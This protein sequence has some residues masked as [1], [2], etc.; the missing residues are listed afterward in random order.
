MSSDAIRSWVR[1]RWLHRVHRTV[2]AVGHRGLTADGRLMAAVLACGPGAVVSHRSAARLWGVRR[3]SSRRI[4]LTIPRS[5]SGMAGVTAY[6][7]RGLR[8]QDVTTRDGFPVT[9]LPRTLIDLAGVVGTAELA[10]AVEAAE[11]LG[12]FDLRAVAEVLERGR[13][14]RGT[15]KLRRLLGAWR[16]PPRTRS[17]MERFFFEQCRQRNL[18]LPSLNTLVE[19]VEVDAY[20]EAEDVIVELDSWEFHGTRAAFERDCHRVL[21]LTWRQLHTDAAWRTLSRALRLP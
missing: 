21:P 15:A 13:G 10:N 19:G 18:P 16:E 5:R 3:S 2:Y 17:E 6:R 8:P 11:R 4:E 20:W 14:R 7:S 12:L 1:R 9:S